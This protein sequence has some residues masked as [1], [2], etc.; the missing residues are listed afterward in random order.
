MPDVSFRSFAAPVI[1]RPLVQLVRKCNGPQFR[2]GFTWAQLFHYVE[3]LSF[4]VSPLAAFQ[5][6]APRI[7]FSLAD[8]EPHGKDGGEWNCFLLTHANIVD[9][10]AILILPQGDA[11]SVD[12]P[13]L[14]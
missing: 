14:E 9:T 4:C 6:P 10:M 12:A 13:R 2:P 1:S 8:L 7:H 11:E 5:S 3:G